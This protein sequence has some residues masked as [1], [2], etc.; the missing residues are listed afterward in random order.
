MPLL[1]WNIGRYRILAKVVD[2]YPLQLKDAFYQECSLCKKE[3]PNKQVA[4]FKCGDSDHEYVR[5]FYQMY[6]MIEDQGGEQI[7]I[8]INDKCPLLNGLKRAHLHDDKSTLH[9][10]CKR[11]DPL[12]GNLTT[13]HDKLVSG[14]TVNLEAV[15]PLLCFEIDTWVVVP[16]AIRAF[17]LNRYEPAPSAS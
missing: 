3:I 10:F 8:S 15:T 7:K 11:V 2:F 9:Q 5:Y 6:I 4:C 13:M 16:E 14:Q 17:S 1:N 12:V